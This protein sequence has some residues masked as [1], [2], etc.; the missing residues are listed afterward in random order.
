MPQNTTT[1]LNETTT[2]LGIAGVYNS[3]GE[4]EA[5]VDGG[6]TL[7]TAGWDATGY[8]LFRVGVFADQAGTLNIQQSIDGGTTWRTFDSVAVVASTPIRLE[9]KVTWPRVRVNY[10]NGA[11]GQGTFQVASAL[12]AEA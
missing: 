12:V 5:Q 8:S 6:L 4:S 1:F 11:T 10:V 3:G 9:A 2:P 7:T